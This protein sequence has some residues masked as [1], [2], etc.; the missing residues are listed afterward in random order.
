MPMPSREGS[1]LRP[2]WR[3]C[4]SLDK[5]KVTNGTPPPQRD[6]KNEDR[7]GYVY[8]NKWSHDKLSDEIPAIYIE[9]TRILKKIAGF[10]GLFAVDCAF[11][12]AFMKITLPD[13]SWSVVAAATTFLPSLF[14]HLP[15]EPTAEDGSCCYRTPRRCALFHYRGW[16]IHCLLF[17][18]STKAATGGRLGGCVGG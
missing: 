13:A 4:Q 11:G 5:Q 18:R 8:E 9:L 17:M 7:S 12:A 16:R 10:E 1:N 6:V 3:L 15:Y 14:A 2:L